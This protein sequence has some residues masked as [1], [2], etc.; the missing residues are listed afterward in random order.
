MCNNTL[1]EDDYKEAVRKKYEKEK[2]GIY[3]NYLNK[4]SQANLRDLCWKIFKSDEKVDD[5]SVY[6]DFFKFNFDAYNENTST[7]YTDKFKKVG[8]FLKRKKEPAKIDTVNLA[9]ILV[10]FELRPYVKFKKK[11]INK[12]N[13]SVEE[14]ESL[15]NFSNPDNEVKCDHNGGVLSNSSNFIPQSY[16]GK[17]LPPP[18]NKMIIVTMVCVVIT[19]CYFVFSKKECMQWSNDHYEE[20]ECNSQ[21]NG[22]VS[23]NKIVPLDNRLFVL[24]KIQ[25]CDTTSFFNKEGDAVVWYAKSGN[26]IDF[27]NTYGR[28]PE[29]GNALRPITKYI[30]DKYVLKNRED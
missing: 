10:D 2:D 8:D 27:F 3:S 21:I 4:P 28:H 16:V 22:L 12:E 5:L 1:D 29:N 23:L 24:R 15:D 19:I 30:I 9:A 26:D 11:G 6:N 14:K 7:V 20:V 13:S 17:V 25:I 18:N